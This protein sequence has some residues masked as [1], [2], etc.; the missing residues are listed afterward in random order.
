MITP[1]N[2][3]NNN[4]LSEAFGVPPNTADKAGMPLPFPLET[5]MNLESE[6]LAAMWYNQN[7]MELRIRFNEGSTYRYDGVPVDVA[8]NL[9][10]AASHGKYFN[11]NIRGKYVYTKL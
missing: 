6:N 2:V 5:W 8:E 11:S 9:Y 10:G 1:I 4:L 3:V 7:R